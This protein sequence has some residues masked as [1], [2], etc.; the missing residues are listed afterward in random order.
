MKKLAFSIVIISLFSFKSFGHIDHYSNFNYL[1]YELFRN[2][3]LIGYHKYSF[4]KENSI[5]AV[6]SEVSFKIKKLGIELYKYYAE[7]IEKYK[8]GSFVGFQ[9]TTNQNK[10]KNTS[11]LLSIQMTQI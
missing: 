8:D 7:G 5:L 1:E 9:S 3:Q 2:N 10:K 6:E 11:T 4:K